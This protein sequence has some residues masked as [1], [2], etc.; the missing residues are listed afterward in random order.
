MD[1]QAAS[2]GSHM[3]TPGGLIRT[4]LTTLLKLAGPVIVSRLG[5]MT[6]G[7]TDAIVVGRY[8]AVQ[9]S[10]HA[11]GWAPSAPLRDGLARTYAWVAA[12]VRRAA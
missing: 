7:L 11:L 9:L 6:M 3:G 10:Y 12:Q 8:S 5:I 1:A 4:D 2:T